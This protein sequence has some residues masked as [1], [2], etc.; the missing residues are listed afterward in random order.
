MAILSSKSKLIKYIKDEEEVWEHIAIKKVMTEE[1][2]TSDYWISN[3][4]FWLIELEANGLLEL[5]DLKEDEGELE[6][7]KLL[8]K[9]RI[10]DYGISRVVSMLED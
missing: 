7:G 8:H 2:R 9:Y 5:V 4:R 1:G 3:A 6:A 10:T